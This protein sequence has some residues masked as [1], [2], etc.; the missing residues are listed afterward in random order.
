MGSLLRKRKSRNVFLCR[1]RWTVTP[2]GV[3]LEVDAV[4]LRAIAVQLFPLALDHPELALVEL[5]QIGRENLKLRQQIELQSLR[6]SRHFGGAQLIEDDLEHPPGSEIH[7]RMTRLPIPVKIS[8]AIVPA[9]LGYFAWRGFA[10]SPCL[11]KQDGFIADL[12][13]W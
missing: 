5:V 9:P 1:T 4:I 3:F 7:A 8:H 12:D 2:S 6:Q 10:R 13:L 11:P